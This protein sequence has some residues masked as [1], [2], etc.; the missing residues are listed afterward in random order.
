MVAITTVAIVGTMST[1]LVSRGPGWLSRWLV[2]GV[3]GLIGLMLV[4]LS[5]PRL[6][7]YAGLARLPA[8]VDANLKSGQPISGATLFEARTAYEQALKYVPADATLNLNLG[9]LILREAA[10]PGLS[11]ALRRKALE[12]ASLHFRA[13]ISGAPTRAFAWSLAALVESNKSGPSGRLYNLLRYSY[14][15]GPY[16]PSSVLTRSGIV[17]P[18]WQ[19]LPDEFQR[20]AEN[21]LKVL[22]WVHALRR[23]LFE[24]YL[25]APYPLRSHIRH[26]VLLTD[27]DRQSFDTL[28]KDFLA[29]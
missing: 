8:E 25:E 19:I 23:D 21:D 24:I 10:M 17:M 3:A 26:V 12:T 13:A 5:T 2:A 28:L 14:Y 7:A 27:E 18:L 1:S 4:V 11:Q 16:E 22:W 29:W 6:V 20:F 15:Y 9:R